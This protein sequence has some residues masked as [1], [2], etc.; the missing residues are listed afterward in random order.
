MMQSVTGSTHNSLPVS[1]AQLHLSS[2]TQVACAADAAEARTVL[3]TDH[4]QVAA[5]EAWLAAPQS[6][7]LV[8]AAT[9]FHWI[10]PEISY[11]KAAQLLKRNGRL[12]IFSNEHPTPYP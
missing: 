9:A 11:P 10:P 8:L 3:P 5:F 1:L 6:F 12:A 7:D 4:I 2:A